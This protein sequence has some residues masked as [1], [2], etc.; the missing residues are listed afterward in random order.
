M[1][2]SS[3]TFYFANPGFN[4]LLSFFFS[5]SYFSLT[6]FSAHEINHAYVVALFPIARGF[7]SNPVWQIHHDVRPAQETACSWATRLAI[8]IEELRFCM[9]HVCANYISV[10]CYFNFV[11][12]FFPQSQQN[13]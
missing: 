5:R 13:H 9:F 7:F 8:A 2:N 12:F 1:M 11:G 6:E 10:A 3:F 4:D